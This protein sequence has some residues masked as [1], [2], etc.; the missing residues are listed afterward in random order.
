MVAARYNEALIAPQM[1]SEQL[2]ASVGLPPGP[3]ID[4]NRSA[5]HIRRTFLWLG[6]LLGAC[7]A[8]MVPPLQ[9]PD[10]FAHFFRSYSVSEGYCVAPV[11]TPIPQMIE[12]MAAAFPP[13][14][15]TQRRIDSAYILRFLRK[16]LQETP[17]D[18]LKNEAINVYNCVP[19]A[20][21]ALG[22]GIGRIL[23]VPPAGILYLARFVNLL[24]YLAV[25]YL[26]LLQLP[27]FQM[28]MLCL[29]LMPMALNQA[30]SASW[31]AVSFSSA[32]FLC[33]YILK[34]AWDE[35]IE[36][37]QM[38][39]YLVLVP[40]IILTSLCKTNIWLLP[41]LIFV[42]ASRFRS[43][44]QKWTVLA[45]FAVLVLVV[46]GGWNYI[47]RQDT[48]L[49]VDH[50]KES[51]QIY[52]SDN[53]KFVF[54]YPGMFL[55]AVVRTLGAH[56]DDYIAEFVG[57]LGWLSVVAPMW[58]SWCYVVLLGFVSLRDRAD[59]RMTLGPS[60]GMSRY[61]RDRGSVDFRRIMGGRYAA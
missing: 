17:Q 39:H 57:K 41:M 35:R 13:K 58:A 12:E 46:V 31:D 37:L 1:N 50:I 28:P 3:V 44:R 9:T 27:T 25:V 38:K 6:A 40:V 30:G 45:G 16:P 53:V 52:F 11:L 33:A 7:Y 29:A 56:W 54:Q 55:Q 26:A 61:F 10:E 4:P 34:L 15:E 22:I 49:W 24:F 18:G 8:I 21:A 42:P 23:S 59:V 60:P 36:V 14:L 2:T 20:P 32:F 43:V 19:Y 5:F 51:Q 48:T 47:N